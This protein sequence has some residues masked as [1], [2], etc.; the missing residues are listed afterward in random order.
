[1]NRH[2][3]FLR[4]ILFMS[5]FVVVGCLIGIAAIAANLHND[6]VARN[7]AAVA[8]LCI[9]CQ[10]GLS[11]F[12]LARWSRSRQ[13]QPP[14]SRL[15]RVERI[16]GVLGAE[17]S[18][19]RFLLIALVSAFGHYFSDWLTEHFFNSLAVGGLIAAMGVLFSLTAAVLAA[20]R[21]AQL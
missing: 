16:A 5:P 9:A 14:P 20:V 1:M 8:F 4:F 15:A 19:L 6:L 7:L 10:I 18:A 3:M 17:T 2:P 21:V 12:T 13:H 11:P